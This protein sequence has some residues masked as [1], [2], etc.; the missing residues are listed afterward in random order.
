MAWVHGRSMRPSALLRALLVAACATGGARAEYGHV[1]A[2]CTATHVD[3]PSIV[4]WFFGSYFLPVE[5]TGVSVVISP[6][7]HVDITVP[8]NGSCDGGE[9]P[10][11]WNRNQYRD[12]LVSAKPWGEASQACSTKLVPGH[13]DL[14]YIVSSEHTISCYRPWTGTSRQV[15]ITDGL[16][17][18]VKPITGAK[19]AQNCAFNEDVGGY[20]VPI[21]TW[22]YATTIGVQA[23]AYRVWLTG[24]TN[25]LRPATDSCHCARAARGAGRCDRAAR[26]PRPQ[27]GMARPRRPGSRAPAPPRPPRR[28]CRQSTRRAPWASASRTPPPR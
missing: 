20:E 18:W 2:V 25:R 27:R 6:P 28:A 17:H 21:K 19:S 15:P 5:D 14:G 4:T 13:D 12:S 3:F 1:V 9:M 16:G 26:A 24:A 8:I 10:T 11:P 7:H 22:Y 23:G